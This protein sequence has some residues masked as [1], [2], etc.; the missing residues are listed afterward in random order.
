VAAGQPDYDGRM[1]SPFPLVGRRCRLR[2]WTADDLAALVRHADNP[3]VAT[4]LRDHFPCPYTDGD[5]RRFLASAT[6]QHPPSALAIEVDSEAGGGIAVIPA[7]GNQ[8]R[9]GEIGYW[10]GESL[11]GRGIAAEALALMTPYAL[12]AFSLVRLEALAVTSNGQSCRVLEKAG[13]VLEGRLRRSFLK[14]G[15]LFDQCLYAWVLE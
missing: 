4:H 8:R 11:W 9:T 3:R 7:S 15:V 5:G 13:Y 6:S 10:L 1:T 12:E 2:P 14:H